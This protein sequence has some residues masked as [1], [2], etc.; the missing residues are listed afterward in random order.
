[1]DSKQVE[2]ITV[3]IGV[4]SLDVEII[5][6]EN[7]YY[8]ITKVRQHFGRDKRIWRDFI[9]IDETETISDNIKKIHGVDAY[10]VFGKARGQKIYVHKTFLKYFLESYDVHLSNE[11]NN[12]L[13]PVLNC[14]NYIVGEKT[15]QANSNGF[16]NASTFCTDCARPIDKFIKRMDNDGLLV[17]CH[18]DTLGMAEFTGTFDD[19]KDKY[20]MK[21]PVDGKYWIHPNIMTELLM[22]ALPKYYRM[23][24]KLLRLYLM[25]PMLGAT[26]F[27]K[28][29]DR[30]TGTKTTAFFK[31][32]N[33]DDEHAK[34]L[35]E[36]L[37][38]VKKQ[39]EEHNATIIDQNNRIITLEQ[40]TEKQTKH[41]QRLKDNVY[42][43][44][45]EKET[46]I[47]DNQSLSEQF[48]PVRALMNDHP[49]TNVG[50]LALTRKA[51]MDKNIYPLEKELNSKDATIKTLQEQL[52][53]E[54]KEKEELY[55][56]L[57]IIQGTMYEEARD[58]DEYIEHL[59]SGY[60]P[61][62]GKKKSYTKAAKTKEVKDA[63]AF[64]PE[65][66]F[67][68]EDFNSSTGI[69]SAAPSG[70]CSHLSV[71]TKR[72]YDGKNMLAFVPGRSTNYKGLKFVSRGIIKLDEKKT[73]EQYLKLFAE[74]NR[75]AYI[76]Y[77]GLTFT[78]DPS[79]TAESFE[80]LFCKGVSEHV[81]SKH[82]ATEY[83]IGNKD[84]VCA[85]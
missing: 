84:A 27:I 1:M 52:L 5:K 43:I 69:T 71:Y 28:E 29:H 79:H 53:L 65:D 9:A 57:S 40:L 68:L 2:K 74:S 23:A 42:Q 46:L 58:K 82:T 60:A 24:A 10:Q 73:T 37:E 17:A 76:K 80:R 67:E 26:E 45:Y 15:F 31:S 38:Y 3:Y 22:Y 70:S 66:K 21:D 33:D 41:I 47:K 83:K 56:E 64:R 59:E 14:K 77:E 78:L 19:I 20:I 12:K 81:V 6:Y 62:K 13:V 72:D 32:T 49:G 61:K 30:Q 85:Y 7:D 39:V 4:Q 48:A 44:T 63:K 8:D 50:Q 34:D 18:M 25:D 35:E 51:M 55:D 54:R 36:Q 16:V 11:K 75:D